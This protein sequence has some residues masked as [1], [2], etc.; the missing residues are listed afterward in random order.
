M[1]KSVLKLIDDT[2]CY[3]AKDG[4]GPRQ[5]SELSVPL[6][7]DMFLRNLVRELAGVLEDIVGIEKASGFISVVGGRVGEMINDIYKEA[8][9]ETCLTQEQ[10]MQVLV[11]LKAR[12]QGEFRLI[13]MDE[14]K[15]V[16]A[17]KVCPFGDKVLDRPSMCMMTSNVFGHITAD[18]LGYAKVEL[19]NT[20]ANGHPQCEVV[21][22]L[23]QTPLAEACD[24]REY[25]GDSDE[26]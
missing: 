22:H 3:V 15:M 23:K 13:E 17:N 7:R 1:P 8:F 21:V 4:A 16:F 5:A 19:Q 6:E 9:G 26:G 10:V 20:I 25:Y 2:T 12:I 24:G 14:D 18:N 11:D